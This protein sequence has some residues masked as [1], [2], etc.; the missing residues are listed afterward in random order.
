MEQGTYLSPAEAAEYGEFKRTR[1]EAEIGI[2]L[3]KLMADGSRRE[4]DKHLLR[5]LCDEVLKLH[6]CGIVVS[7]VNVAEA[8]RRLGE[9]A[10]VAVLA[11]GT[12]ET[13]PAVKRYEVKR[14]VRAGA[15]EVR[16]VPMYSA[17]FAGNAVYLR[18]EVRRVRRAAGKR[19]LILSLED[20]A[21]GERE[22]ALG[23]RAALEG[24]ADGVCVR[25]EI[26]LLT[27]AVKSGAD[28]L[29]VDVSGV[30]NAEQLRLLIKAGAH[31][32][33]TACAEKLAEE[34]YRALEESGEAPPAG[35]EA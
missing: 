20:H 25:G 14:A 11:G 31:R 26:D 29:R 5:T 8:K 4:T 19:A 18:R 30:E 23:V 15:G 7:P 27:C 33:A 1:R 21:I 6:A 32:A 24:R 28:R 13:L 34:M 9:R 35:G 3:Q 10:V 22:I 2:T 12:G 17:L 16:L